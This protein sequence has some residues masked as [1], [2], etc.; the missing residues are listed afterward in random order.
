MAR[1][2]VLDKY[3][4]DQIAAGEVVERPSSVV[5]ELVEN[6]IDAGA[7]R[8]AI[9]IEDGGL[10]MI[11]V[12]DDGCGIEGDDLELA[13]QR[14]ATSKI[15]STGDLACIY[16][17]GFRGE[18]LP[19]IAAVSKLTVT[20][21]T[22]DAMTGAQAQ[23][24]GG[25]LVAMVPAGAPP[26][27][28]VT[29][30][31]LFYNTP[32]RRKT[33]KSPATEG[34]LCGE[35]VSRLA[36]AR[37]DIRYEM[38]VK[39]RDVFYSAGSGRLADA[40]TAVYGAAMAREMVPL[41]FTEEGIT[42][43]GMVGKPS[44][45]RSTRNHITLV[46]N[47]RY[48]RCTPVTA[49]VEAAYQTLLPQGRKPVVILSL[50]I[51]PELLDVNVHPAKLEVRLLEEEKMAVLVKRALL[52]ALR[53][54]ALIPSA[55]SATHRKYQSGLVV[56]PQFDTP[57]R[58]ER[59]SELVQSRSSAQTIP[60]SNNSPSIT[61]T[62]PQPYGQL[63][64]SRLAGAEEPAGYDNQ[65]VPFP[66]L[67]PLAQLLPLYILAAGE[68]GL[69]IIDQHAAHERVLYEDF[70]A[71][72]SSTQSQ[73]LLGP[74][75]LEL[76]YREAAL[77]TERILWFTEAG[78]I[79][80]HFGGNTF[81]LRGVPSRFPAGQEKTIFF[82]LLDYFREKGNDSSRTEFFHVLAASLAC[83]NAVK[84]GEKLTLAA[85]EALL[86]SLSG[87]VNP[88]TCPHGRPAVIKIT[89]RDLA[90]RFKR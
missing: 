14:H 54:K 72:Q 2:I 69:Y 31:E 11:T 63:T 52:E 26:G 55:A 90:T 74:V 88:F 64:E 51:P 1:I 8:I 76:D 20:T 33:M 45:S 66:E 84:S 48:V 70:L 6:S 50:S 75:T 87:K 62:T 12:S 61:S 49:A 85:M 67:Q 25:A 13:F 35:L 38:R 53:T 47:G 56:M 19:S 34:S 86:R 5:K 80:E 65:V 82:D 81:L 18:A 24:E 29:V 7:R 10:S 43:T 89:Y 37:P 21:R 73:C 30:K 36:L 41:N 16:T 22:H 83:K 15:T 4:A 44:I 39:G 23:I 59:F 27:T 78:F 58:Q 32:A 9:D 28:T 79:I 42:I 60:E 3:T 57:V 40:A 17:L 77:L 68:D 71:G 46:I